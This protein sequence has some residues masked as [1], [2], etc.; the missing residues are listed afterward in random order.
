ME[1]QPCQKNPSTPNSSRESLGTEVDTCPRGPCVASGEPHSIQPYRV[2]RGSDAADAHFLCS[3]G[4]N[5]DEGKNKNK[6][7]S[8]TGQTSSGSPTVKIVSGTQAAQVTT[9]SGDPV[10]LATYALKNKLTTQDAGFKLL[11][12]RAAIL[13]TASVKTHSPTVS[14]AI[15]DLLDVVNGLLSSRKAVNES[16]ISLW[17]HVQALGTAKQEKVVPANSTVTS[18]IGTQTSASAEIIHPTTAETGTDTPCWWGVNATR[19]ASQRKPQIQSSKPKP[20]RWEQQQRQDS[21]KEEEPG[22]QDSE[23]TLV[24]RKKRKKEKKTDAPAVRMD[25]SSRR[26][27]LPKTQAVVLD[28]PA[29][30][31]SYADMVKEVKEA[32]LQE[33]FTHE[34]I[35][36]KAKSGNMILVTSDKEKA[37][38]LAN[39]LRR[40]FGESKGV[41]RP[42]LS[43]ALLFIGIEDSVDDSE[44][45]HI[46]EIHNQN[47]KVNLN[48]CW[49]A[50]QLLTQ[51]TAERNADILVVSDYLRDLGDDAR[52]VNSC[53]RKCAVLVAGRSTSIISD[54]GAGVGFAWAKVGN[55]LVYSCYCT[56][57]CSIQVFDSF[58]NGIESSV[59]GQNLTDTHLIVAG[60]FNA[61]SAEW[62]SAT[63][64]ARGSL[65][66]GLASALGLNV[67]N[68]GTEP[69]YRRVNAASVI[70]VTFS[71]APQLINNWSV[72]TKLHS[73]SDHEYIEYTVAPPSGL[74]RA[75]SADRSTEIGGWA[76]KKLFLEALNEHFESTNGVPPS[77]PLALSAEEHAEILQDLL[78]GACEASMPRR[79]K[80]QGRKAVHWWSQD[81][82]NLRKLVIAA[83]RRYQRAGRRAD[84]QDRA[85]EFIEY[86]VA[87][88]QLRLAIR[89][90]EEASWNKLCNSVENDPWGVPYRLVTKR[91]GRRSPAMDNHAALEIARGLFP[92]NPPIEWSSTPCVVGV[93]AELATLTEESLPL[94]TR[95][96]LFAAAKDL[97]SGKAPGPDHVPNE[98]I[99]VAVRKKAESFLSA[100]NECLKSGHFPVCWKSATLVL[101]HKGPT[102]HLDLPSSY[103]P[104]SLLDGAG[105]LLERL[106][107]ARLGEHLRKA[108]ALSDSQYDFRRSRSTTDTISEVLSIAWSAGSA[109]V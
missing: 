94:F 77:T 105:K 76:I 103:R 63:N 91:L 13:K 2:N 93:S 82:A 43:I 95:D 38:N 81:I 34:I 32:V 21:S 66:S 44:L 39:I 52:R 35:T 30:T 9:G 59:R 45:K 42:S 99:K 68:E 104:I 8:T 106:L 62:G 28:K 108:N 4:N 74:A 84:T 61:H 56:P 109:A 79:T 26:R 72:L 85:A 3:R 6:P 10:S 1:G 16:F 14:S 7:G 48:H 12:E 101:L 19:T 31:S 92:S 88:K 100:F 54:K 70:D 78:T 90:A 41:R 24:E 18:T 23:F 37:D 57:N 47:L 60:D 58:L 65:L 55:T 67:C 86:N 107:L 89:K 5:M 87:R 29:G 46:L 33:D 102:K 49:T 71:N 15:S 96:E 69:T 53:D 51:T 36:R 97:P 75:S 11:I 80:F 22:P 50:Q 25:P 83:R 98:V 27:W 17:H 40:K 20:L 64:D 73:A